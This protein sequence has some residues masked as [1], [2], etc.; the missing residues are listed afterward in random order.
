MGKHFGMRNIVTDIREMHYLYSNVI[1]IV[2]VVVNYIKNSNNIP[3]IHYN[4]KKLV[5]YNLRIV[6]MSRDMH[7][8]FK[9]SNKQNTPLRNH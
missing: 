5:D 1:V 3:C 7:S 6:A 8:R 2:Y 9:H 4:N